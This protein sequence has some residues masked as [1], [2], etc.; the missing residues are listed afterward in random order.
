MFSFKNRLLL[1]LSLAIIFI[2]LNGVY[3]NDDFNQTLG[4]NSLDSNVQVFYVD[5]DGND[6]NTGLSK[7]QSVKSLNKV[8]DSYNSSNDLTIYIANGIYSSENNTNV[9]LWYNSSKITIIGEDLNKTILNGENLHKFFW[10]SKDTNVVLANLT[11]INGYDTVKG[12]A[13]ENYGNL[14]LVNC[15]LKNNNISAGPSSSISN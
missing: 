14:T 2:C 6:N 12:G 13:I 8:F 11:L 10:I 15:N 3:A 9:I 5:V 7:N 1:V 4:D